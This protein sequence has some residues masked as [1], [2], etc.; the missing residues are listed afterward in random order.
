MKNLKVVNKS[1]FVNV[2]IP[3]EVGH[4]KCEVENQIIYYF[5]KEDKL[6]YE[7][8]VLDYNNVTYMGISVEGNDGFKKLREFYEDLGIDLNDLIKKEV[9]KFITLENCKELLKSSIKDFESV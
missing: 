8:E 5:D 6:I 1:L 3:V 2:V 9:S 4:V 7:I